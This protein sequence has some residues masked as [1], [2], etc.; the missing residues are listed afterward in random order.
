MSP[1][2]TVEEAV[3]SLLS[4]PWRMQLTFPGDALT[5]MVDTLTYA[6]DTLT[7]AADTLFD[8]RGRHFDHD[9]RL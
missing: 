4:L 9:A 1:T 5:F 3:T 7:Y 6:A 2:P 8:I